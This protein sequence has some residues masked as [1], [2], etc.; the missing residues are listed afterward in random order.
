MG[1]PTVTR[2]ADVFAVSPTVCVKRATG[3]ARG[4]MLGW[5]EKSQRGRSREKGS[6]DTA[7]QFLCEETH[8]A[9]RRVV[10]PVRERCGEATQ[11]GFS[12]TK[13]QRTGSEKNKGK[14]PSAR[15]TRPPSPVFA[16]ITL[17]RRG[18]APAKPQKKLQTLPR[19]RAEAF[20][21]CLTGGELAARVKT[22]SN[23]YFSFYVTC[24]HHWCQ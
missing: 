19:S 11:A 14:L 6:R 20:Q 8:P 7:E 18:E 13:R 22:K 21:C 24:T 3:L 9:R 5:P 10:L 4:A 1:T 17:R 2:P 23:V 12:R 15:E 16:K